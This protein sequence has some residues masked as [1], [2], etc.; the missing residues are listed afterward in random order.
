MKT[1]LIAGATGLCGK[2]L[3]F[4]LLTNK[5]YTR[6]FILV[7]KELAIKDPKLTQIIFNYDN[8]KDFSTIPLG[9]EVYCCL[10]TTIKKAGSES[11]FTKVDYDYPL[12]L[13][14]ASQQIGYKSFCIITAMGA[15]SSSRFFY[16]R[17]KGNLEKSLT[18]IPFETTIICKPSLLIGDRSEFRIGELVGKYLSTFLSFLFIGSLKKYRAIQGIIVAKAMIVATAD[19][20]KGYRLIES[21][22]LQEL[23]ENYKA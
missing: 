21:D 14:K 17:V 7:R 5:N 10:G 18:E 22:K 16:N 13:A 15:D 23:G 19:S 9:D 1:A 11:A 3:L 6:V 12:A 2:N 4:T 20:S 8:I